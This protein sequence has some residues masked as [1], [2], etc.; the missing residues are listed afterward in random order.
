VS[1]TAGPTEEI[2]SA[3]ADGSVRSNNQVWSHWSNAEI[4]WRNSA[5]GSR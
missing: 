4:F 3:V 5:L 2:L 1:A